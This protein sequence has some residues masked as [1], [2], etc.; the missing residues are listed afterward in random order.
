MYNPNKHLLATVPKDRRWFAGFL[1]VAVFLFFATASSIAKSESSDSKLIEYLTQEKNTLTLVINQLKE[2]VLP[3]NEAQ[4]NNLV[5]QNEA[6]MA[7]NK[8]KIANF[9]N[10]LVNQNKI[11]EDFSQRLKQLQQFTA[12]ASPQISAQQKIDKINTLN[13][14]NKKTISLIQENIDLANRYQRILMAEKQALELWQARE[15][16]HKQLI[17]LH[18][19]ED[20]LNNSLS[21]LYEKSIELQQSIKANTDFKT[22]YHLEARLLLNNQLINLTQHKI[23]ELNLQRKL[24]RADYLL[25]KSPD[26]RTLQTVTED[27][28]NTISQLSDLEQALRKMASVLKSEQQHL[29]DNALKQQFT[30]LLR[31]IDARLEGVVIQQQTLQEDLENH[32]EEL[33]K[34][35]SVRQSLSE[36]RM[37]SWP[38]IF[39][40]LSDIPGQ[41]YNY[42]KTLALKLRDNYQWQDKLPAFLIWFSLGLIILATVGL[43][44]LLKQMTRDKE[45]SR[46]SGHLYDGLLAILSRNMPHIGIVT[47]VIAVFY[48]NHVP[49]SNYQLLIN[50]LVIW[51]IF[52]SLILIARLALLERLSDYSGTDV[53][54]YYRLKWLLMAGG[55]STALMT[56][57]HLLP[58]SLI[59]Q[60]I[61]NRMFMIFLVAVSIVGWKSRD[62]ITHLL[63]PVL[64]SKKRYFRHAVLLLIYLV[65]ITLFTTAVIGLIGYINLAWTMSSYQIEILVLLC[66]YVL[67]RG[68]IFDGMELISEWMIYRM[69]NGWLWIEVWLKPLDKILRVLLLVLAL[70]TL[71]QLFGWRSDSV[72]MTNLLQFSEY[73]LVNLS[74]VHITA[75]SILKFL[76]LLFLFIWASKWTRE[77]C[78]R[79]LYRNA[80]DAGIR[81]SLSVFTQYAVILIGVFITLRTL[82]LDFSGMAMV[83]GGLAVGMG[84]GLRDFASNIVG[85]IML[86]IERPV[87]EGDLITLGNY[88]GRVAHIGIRSMRVSSWDNMEVLIPNA[89]TFNKP[90]TNWTHQDSIVRTV[91]P[92]KVS[93]A[94]DPLM[95][96]QLILDVL[97]IIPEIV[98]EPPAQVFLKQIDEAL[99]EFEVRYFINVQL[100]SRFEI[101]SKVLF[102]INA[103]FKA[104]GVKPPIP[105]I[106]VEVRESEKDPARSLPEK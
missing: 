89:E 38:S 84:F 16:L 81:N 43:Y 95:I 29:S 32:Q 88:E 106:S 75:S 96:Q 2:P 13:E 14:I 39:T 86:L 31:A 85:G 9:E 23:S 8:A 91:V 17:T 94:D 42:L 68:L 37:D 30:N 6:R 66:L 100:Y 10:F 1:V 5:R 93:R 24:A 65:P 90:F 76:I 78:Y 102:A 92:I 70:Y 71:F 60:D 73:P 87:R 7:L 41:F 47:A 61:F 33:K 25:L 82:G 77:F 52:R 57:S 69:N 98:G 101:R 28:K 104:A 97:A 51:L 35:L 80:R 74:G 55:W 56:F 34:Q 45:R 63:H 67:L 54:L 49:F 105:P 79:W 22:T 12:T 40:Q 18:E 21:G 58:L 83:L 59:L 99:I 103:Q 48:F 15:R 11:Q 53:R 26:I 36:Y 50:L 72:V 27:Y 4:Y 19:Q 20:R 46:L 64:K 44:K 62:V 3:A